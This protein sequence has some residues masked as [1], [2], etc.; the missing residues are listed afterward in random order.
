M[1][2]EDD[3]SPFYHLQ[4]STHLNVESL[5]GMMIGK[6]E[7]ADGD[8]NDKLKLTLRGQ[9]ANHFE[10]DNNGNLY[11]RPEQIRNLNES[12]IH[13]I[14]VA[15]DSGVP[16]RSASVGVTVTLEGVALNYAKWSNN[17]VGMFGLIVTTSIVVIFALSCYIFHFKGKSKR[18]GTRTRNKV[19]HTHNQ[20]PNSSKSCVNL[21]NHHEKHPGASVNNSGNT[22]NT[23][24]PVLRMN[25]NGNIT[26]A[27]PFNKTTTTT[28]YSSSSPPMGRAPAAASS[29]TL[30]ER[31]RDWQRENYAATVRSNGIIILTISPFFL[32]VK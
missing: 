3:D 5:D 25:N 30:L 24:L 12:T 14:A 6:I 28:P 2:K 32:V 20:E 13:L 21:V 27:N 31:D 16:P 23:S 4:Q 19:H 8:R 18:N 11:M 1:R 10:I 15:T 26:M 29:S 22:P 7:A 9:Y 17:V